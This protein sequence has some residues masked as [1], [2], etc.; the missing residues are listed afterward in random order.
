MFLFNLQRMLLDAKDTLC[1]EMCLRCVLTLL[2]LIHACSKSTR[3]KEASL[4]KT[5]A[6]K[7]LTLMSRDPHSR[8]RSLHVSR[9]WRSVMFDGRT[10]WNY[11]Y[12]ELISSCSVW[13]FFCIIISFILLVSFDN[14]QLYIYIYIYR[15]VVK[16]WREAVIVVRAILSKKI[17]WPL[18]W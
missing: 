13:S 7:V 3:E 12:M 17:F 9:R 16:I 4:G 6:S 14:V 11:M 8:F 15:V 5:E 18:I 10:A 2:S 1:G